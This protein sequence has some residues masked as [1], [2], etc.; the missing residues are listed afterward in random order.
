M[1]LSRIR[2]RENRWQHTD[3]VRLNFD[4]RLQ[5]WRQND[6]RNLTVDKDK[7][8]VIADCDAL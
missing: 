4:M 6:K 1:D 8:V 7:V 2:M 3:C 5:N